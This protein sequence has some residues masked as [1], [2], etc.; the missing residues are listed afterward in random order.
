MDP[1][2][3]NQ[4]CVELMRHPRVV[5][6]MWHAPMFWHVD[7]D[8]PG[9]ADLT[10]PRVDLCELEVMLAT[11]AGL[12]SE[13]AALLEQRQPGRAQFIARSVRRGERPW[14][15]PVQGVDLL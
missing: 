3:L 1:R 10:R 6:Q 13:C 12:P 4:R 8:N 9:P 7:K 15:A 11:A 5:A 2:A 14:L